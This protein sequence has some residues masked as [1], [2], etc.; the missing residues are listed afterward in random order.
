MKLLTLLTG[1]GISMSIA[2]AA[3]TGCLAPGVVMLGATVLTLRNTNDTME[4]GNDGNGTCHWQGPIGERGLITGGVGDVGDQGDIGDKGESGD[5]PWLQQTLAHP[6]NSQSIQM[7]KTEAKKKTPYLPPFV[8]VV[9]G[10][11]PPGEQGDPGQQ[12]HTGDAGENPDVGPSTAL[13][14]FGVSLVT[15][16]GVGFIAGASLTAAMK[17][18]SS[19]INRRNNR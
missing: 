12:G 6:S 13:T 2:A 19:M 15:G 11:G 10:E 18:Y 3:S 7:I 5:P 8:K 1:L 14:A 4:T 16:F 9:G 17:T